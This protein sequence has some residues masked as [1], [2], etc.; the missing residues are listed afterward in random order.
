MTIALPTCFITGANGF[1][2][3][4]LSHYLQQNGFTVRGS[5]RRQFATAPTQIEIY[6]TGDIDGNT[7]WLKPLQ[8]ADTVI[9]LAGTV[10]RPDI[11]DSVVYQRSIVDATAALAKQAAAAQVKRFIY[12]SSV[13]VYGV[14]ASD[15]LIS[16][17]HACQPITAYAQAKWQAE[18]LLQPYREQNEMEVVI[19]R[20][21]L[22][23]GSGVGG[24]FAQLI[25]LVKMLPC[26]PLGC[27]KQPRSLI[28]LDNL[29]HFLQHTIMHPHSANTTFNISDAQDISTRALC[30]ILAKCLHK[31][32]IF[33]PIPRFLMQ[34]GLKWLGKEAMYDKLFASMRLD[35][36]R[37]KKQL[38]WQPPFSVEEQIAKMF[39]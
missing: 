12:I 37:A 5:V 23:Y 35:V 4:A 31:K 1:I 3:R 2:G 34:Q 17:Q 22:V 15:E 29:M 33:L 32:R 19:V 13:H 16:E 36:Q 24:N 21:P 38:G 30:E 39:L 28:G 18:K 25:K 26:L 9:H 7:N 6:P 10:H 14:T 8:Q 20:L 27:A 11:Q